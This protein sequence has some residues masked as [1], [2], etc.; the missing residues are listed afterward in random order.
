MARFATGAATPLVAALVA[1]APASAAGESAAFSPD[2]TWGSGYQ[3]KYTITA[4][5]T[6]PAGWKPA[7]TARVGVPTIG[8]TQAPQTSRPTSP[9]VGRSTAWSSPRTD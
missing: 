3:G 7:F 6:A 8:L 4:G 2:S 5:T 1:I 9:A